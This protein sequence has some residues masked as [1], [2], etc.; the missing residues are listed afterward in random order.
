[1]ARC[2]RTLPHGGR[3]S[4][5]VRCRS[6]VPN[7]AEHRRT[8]CSQQRRRR[9]DPRPGPQRPRR[10]GRRAGAALRRVGDDR[11]PRPRALAREGKLTR[12]HGGAV[13][14]P[15]R[16]AVRRRSRRAPRR[17][18]PD[19]PRRGRL[20]EDGQTV[21]I[22][23]G[24][25]T[26]ELARHL[27]GRKLTVITS[28]LAVVEELLPEPTIELVV[29]GGVVRRN[30][31]SL[32][33]VLAEDALRQLSADVAFL[34]ASGIREDLSVMDTTMVEVPIKRGMIAAA[35]RDGPAR[36]RREVRDDA[37]RC[38][39]AAPTSSTSSSP[40]R[41]PAQPGS[42]ALARGR[43]SRWCAH[44]D[45][46][47]RRRRVPRAAGLRRAA[48]AG[49][50][51]RAR[52]RSRST[53]STSARLA[54]IAP[55]ARGARAEQRQRAAV[56]PR[57]PTSTTRSR[58]PTSSSARS[59]SASSRA[60]SS[61]SA[62]RSTRASSA[63]RRPGP[64]GICFALRTV[65]GDGA[66]SR[67]ARRRA[68]RRSAWFV[69]F[70]NPAGLVTEAIQRRARRPRDRHLRLAGRALPPRRGGARAASP[71]SS[72]STTSASTTSAGCAASTTATRDLLPGLLA[73][74]ERLASFEEGRLF[75][76]EWLRALGMIPNEYLFF[77]Y[78]ASDT[79]GAI[80]SGLESRGEFLLHQQAA[81]YG[82]NG[83]HARGGAR[84]L[85]R[86]R[87]ASARRRTSPRRT[88]RP[89]IGATDELG[90][91][92]R[93]RGRGDRR[94]R[95]DRAQPAPRADPRTPRT[96]AACRSSTS[97]PSS[98]CRAS[99]AAPA[100]VP[101]AVGDVPG[102]AR[103]LIESIK[104]VERTDDRRG[105]HAARASSR[106]EGAR[107]A[108]ARAVRQRRAA[109]LRRLLP[110]ASPS[111]AELFS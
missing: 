104:E 74:D 43:A 90:G 108:P 32:V 24:T 109:Y 10:G 23:I 56:P 6:A 85:A 95:G 18:G 1:M 42:L 92:R 78:F 4:V 8:R 77:Y 96:A 49:R 50:A 19:R 110:A 100:R 47:P 59:A 41:P 103:A 36:R 53:T 106:V 91:R 68:A 57:R 31:R 5:R 17:E 63:R 79:V 46:D 97:A 98:R 60:A 48:R 21:M 15:R 89:G 26:L 28:N 9:A 22:D 11:A 51:A 72:G 76:G 61:T 25:T 29:L 87:G 84:G 16:A 75:G 83:A 93:L 88:P 58:A 13:S 7:T 62:C 55:R 44:E 107:A 80:R 81:F 64:A 45:R 33:G 67:E 111:C 14:E 3:T 54:Q 86:A 39:S 94:R 82:A 66:S 102:H 69:N 38:A 71:T 12:V 35:E 2:A 37:A 99:S 27:H 101:I 40:T 70:T 105:A 65:P 73:D 34:G 30:Y 52:A 20:V